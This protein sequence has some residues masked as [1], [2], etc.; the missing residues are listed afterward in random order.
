[1]GDAIQVRMYRDEDLPAVLELLRAALGESPLLQ[2]TPQLF[3]WKHIDNPF[4]RSVIL[5]AE[6]DDTI[7]GLRAFM[8][9]QLDHGGDLIECGRAVD[10]ATHPNY[11][12]RG[13]FKRLTM[14]ALEVAREV[15]LQLIFNTPNERSRPGYLKMGWSDVGPIR[16]L[17]R[18]HPTRLLRARSG[19][20]PNLD[21]L[22]PPAIPIDSDWR[23]AGDPARGHTDTEST[24]TGLRTRR[25]S[26]YLT[27]RFAAHPTARYGAV[28]ETSGTAVVRPNLRKGRA[29]L[30]ISDALGTSPTEAVRA[31]VRGSKADYDVAAFPPGSPE[32]YAAQ[33]AGML[34][35][36]GVAALRLVARPIE[37]LD[38]DVLNPESWR[39]ALSDVELL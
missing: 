35:I 39:L 5:V 3:R 34:P 24:H 29:E 19:S 20:F 26:P 37:A 18:P 2:R 33:R 25:S 23:P 4:G 27:W 6:I 17:I 12:R 10:T 22:V 36:P 21:E 31:A 9:W 13:I 28:A 1:M 7:V 16:V 38:I 32:R 11:L 14:E 8:R 15:G 30:V